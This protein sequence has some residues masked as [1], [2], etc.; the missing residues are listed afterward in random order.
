[1]ARRNGPI[2]IQFPTVG[3][4]YFTDDERFAV[5]SY[6]ATKA[7]YDRQ[8]RQIRDLL[9]SARAYRDAKAAVSQA[10]RSALPG[11]ARLE[12]LIRSGLRRCENFAVIDA[13]AAGETSSCHGTADRLIQNGV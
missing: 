5:D 7:T 6:S 12:A 9:A 1:M 2:V 10:D 3:Q 4:L 8:L 11:N 13:H